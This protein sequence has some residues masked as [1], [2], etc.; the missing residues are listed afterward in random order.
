MTRPAVRL[1]ERRPRELRLPPDEVAFLLAHARHVVEVAPS[2]RRGRYRVTARNHVG[3]FDTPTRRFSIVPKIPW[4][5]VRLLLG[6]PPQPGGGAA[7][8]DSGVLDVLAREFAARLRE[9]TRTGLVPG[10]RDRDGT[11]V[12][13]RGKLRAADQMRDVA[14]RAFPDRFHVTESVLD[15]DTPWNRVVRATADALAADP[16][17]TP[18]VRVEVCDA[19]VALASVSPVPVT[20]AD[21]PRAAEEPRAAHY[22]PLLAVCRVLHGGFRA[23]ALTGAAG[24]FLVD[25]S[26]AFERYLADGLASA[27]ARW[28]A[29]RV[30]AQ[31]GFP[32]GPTVLQPDVL[33]RRRDVPRF[34]LDAKWKSPGG[35]PDANDLHQVLA[36]AAVAGAKCVGLVYP[37]R[38]SARRTFAVPGSH[39]RVSLLRVRVV[40]TVE[41]C[42]RSLAA[43]GRL[44]RRSDG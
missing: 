25:L 44:V 41:E 21:F 26:R 33:V 6:L 22:A 30:E 43:L 34:V 9:V 3:T 13:L 38:R 15:L 8:P 36:Y 1:V 14:A 31:P 2:F 17:L 11:A 7:D 39:I 23:A 18:A 32:A 12:F 28:P 35:A 4:P 27:L 37:G 10:Y 42:G 40:G 16:R 20:D 5:N 19:A 24:G 29:W